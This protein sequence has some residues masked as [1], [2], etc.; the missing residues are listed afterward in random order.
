MPALTKL[1]SA[2]AFVALVLPSATV[3]AQPEVPIEDIFDNDSEFMR[4]FETGLFLR[5]KGGTIDEYGCA[6]RETKKKDSTREAFEMIKS[7]IDIARA[8]VQMDPVID[9]ALSIVVDIMDTLTYYRDLLS[10][11]GLKQLD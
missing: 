7:N 10:K 8:A 9:N 6:I 5:T 11:E 4:G 2:I 3:Q 1:L